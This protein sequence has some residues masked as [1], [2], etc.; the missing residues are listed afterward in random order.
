M[1]HSKKCSVVASSDWPIRYLLLE[2][3]L[4]NYILGA[5]CSTRSHAF[6]VPVLYVFHPLSA[7]LPRVPRALLALVIKV[8][9]VL[10]AVVSQV[11][12]ALH[13]LVLHMPLA[14]RAIVPCGPHILRV[15]VPY[16]PRSWRA[17]LSYVSC[18]L[19][20]FVPHSLVP[21]MFSCSPCL[22]CLVASVPS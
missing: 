18:I 11:P 5:S 6:L 20:A 22:M 2:P 21:C 17:F 4:L 1:L 8:P 10:R 16:L 13:V 3:S 15:L 9:L 19:R 7:L 12:C 14:L